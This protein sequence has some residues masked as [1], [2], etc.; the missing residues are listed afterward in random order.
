MDKEQ[1]ES[2]LLADMQSDDSWMVNLHSLRKF[3]DV[4]FRE[5]FTHLG[6][7][8]TLA[9]EEVCFNRMIFSDMYYAQNE[10]IIRLLD[11]YKRC[12]WEKMRESGK[13]AARARPD[14]S[15][16]ENDNSKALKRAHTKL[17]NSLEYLFYGPWET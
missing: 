14:V 11:D 1:L 4:A 10:L 17:A 6:Q 2:Y 9:R 5:W 13:H 15:R 12:E 3:D 8:V 7:Y 16:E